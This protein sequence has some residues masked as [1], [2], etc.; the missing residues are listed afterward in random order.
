MT[1]I[2]T[3]PALLNFLIRNIEELFYIRNIEEL[4]YIRKTLRNCFTFEAQLILVLLK[5][6]R[7]VTN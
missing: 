6:L 4:F 5:K 1:E 7:S 2:L 3:M